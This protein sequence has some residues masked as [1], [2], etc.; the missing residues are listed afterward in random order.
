MK[1]AHTF[2]R[3]SPGQS[4]GNLWGNVRFPQSN[5]LMVC[6]ILITPTCRFDHGVRNKLAYTHTHQSQLSNY[7]AG[8]SYEQPGIE[9]CDRGR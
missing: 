2:A 4:L 7:T 6:F 1:L 8:L 5:L 3:G 9:S